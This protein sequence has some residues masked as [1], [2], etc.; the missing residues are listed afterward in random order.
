MTK[1]IARYT[2]TNGLSGC[3]MPDN[4]SGPM[5]FTTRRELA[6]FIRD[7]IERMDWPKSMFAEVGI[8]RLWSFIARNGSS[9]A[10]FSISRKGY[11]LAFHGLTEAEYNDELAQENF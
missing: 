11:E 1:Q 4:N 6:T 3:Y 9:V 7:E 10:H 8:K 5:E 2:V